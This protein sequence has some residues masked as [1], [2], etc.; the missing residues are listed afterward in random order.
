MN[1]SLWGSLLLLAVFAGAAAPARAAEPAWVGNWVVTDIDRDEEVDLFLF[2][3][4]DKDGKPQVEFLSSG[5]PKQLPSAKVEDPSV[6]AGVIKLP[7]NARGFLLNTT[8]YLP[9]GEEKP[10]KLYGFMQ[11][12]DRRTMVELERQR[13]DGTRSE[14]VHQHGS[15]A[16]PEARRWPA[17]RRN[18]P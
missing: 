10:K 5:L 7:I 3:I 17:R 15:G 14:Q 2:K 16:G 13:P 4:T 6:A 1:R 9:K 12:S 18:R 8:F 11:L